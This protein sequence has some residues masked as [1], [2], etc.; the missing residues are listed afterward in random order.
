M[1]GFYSK[2][3]SNENYD[4][5]SMTLL[6]HGIVPLL[7]IRGGTFFPS[8]GSYSYCQKIQTKHAVTE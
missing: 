3:A 5:S 2:G 1:S 4:Q 8:V 7:G 6:L